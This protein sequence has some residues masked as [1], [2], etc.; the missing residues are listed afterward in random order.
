MNRRNFLIGS[1]VLGVVGSLSSSMAWSQSLSMPLQPQ[2]EAGAEVAPRFFSMTQSY[3]LEAPYGSQG[4]MRLWI[5]LPEPMAPYQVLRR[6]HWEGDFQQASIVSEPRF[7]VQSLFVQ[8]EDCQGPMHLD[9]VM[10]VE[11]RDWLLGRQGLLDDYKPPAELIY[12]VGVAPYLQGSRH[13]KIDG[14]VAER[15]QEIVGNE[16]NPLV[17]A[18]LIHDWVAEHMERD[19]SVIG[20][21][22]GDVGAILE[23][24]KLYGK[25][26]DINS[27]FVALARAAGIPA[28][29]M[30]GIR[31]GRPAALEQYSKTAFGSADEQG[32]ANNTDWQ[33][34]RAQFWLP[35][36][37]WVPCDPADVT[38]MRL[39]ENKSHI[40]PAVQAVNEDLFGNW[41][42]NWVGFNYGRDFVLAPAPEQAPINNFGYPYAEAGGDP[43]NYYD[44]ARF[45]YDYHTTEQS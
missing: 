40:D 8:W 32:Q 25:C 4:E 36:M 38:K 33:H 30:F 14:V 31:L 17:R 29:E 12:P 15:A 9:V 27:V 7:G 22:V 43:L 11:T 24:G 23:S 44:F 20:C 34:C 3:E 21:G 45:K 28:R 18:R 6:L 13:I 41:E 16:D 2:Q 1:S 19:N 5:P 39:A 42:M 26:T 37:G 10:D 35:G